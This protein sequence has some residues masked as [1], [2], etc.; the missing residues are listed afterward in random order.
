MLAG[1]HRTGRKCWLCNADLG[2]SEPVVTYPSVR[3][4]AFLRVIP[5]E[6]R[7][8]DYNHCAARVCNTIL[9]RLLA[10]AEQVGLAPRRALLDLQQELE[11]EAEK[12]PAAER[13]APRKIKP[14]KLDLTQAK[15]LLQGSGGLMR[16]MVTVVQ[17]NLTPHVTITFQGSQVG[18]HVLV[19]RILVNLSNIHSSWR[20][21]AFW[22]DSETA[23]YIQS[24]KAF[25]DGWDTCGWKHSPWVHWLVVH[26]GHLATMYRSFEAFSSIPC[27]HRHKGFKH[28]L[29]NS[30][31]AGT[32]IEQL[33]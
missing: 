26:S 4:G 9:K 23:L 10:M 28:D 14:G 17:T 18:L 7:I 12:I 16:K 11:F 8:G 1:H 6:R 24:V 29:L 19:H 22:T 32:V 30:L 15:L 25:A 3:Y 27:E 21:K 20:K 2:D 13:I 33:E 31:Q 5:P